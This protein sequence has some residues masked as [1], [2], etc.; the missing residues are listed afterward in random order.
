MAEF[1]Q[2]TTEVPSARTGAPMVEQ[3]AAH[4]TR[5]PM[6]RHITAAVAAVGSIALCATMA[7]AGGSTAYADTY[8]STQAAVAATVTSGTIPAGQL[9]VVNF[10]PTWGD[11]QAN[12][13]SMLKYIADA[14]ANGV[15]MIVFPEMAL[16]GYVSSNDPDSAAYR[17]AVSQA[18][19]TESPITR[20]IAQAAAAN[21]M[22][23]IYGTSEKIPGDTSHAYN[24]AFAI[25]PKGHT[26]RSHRSKATGPHRAVRQS[27]CR[28][29]GA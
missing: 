14:H 15:K 9:A 23:V 22:W 10:H 11:K 28:P 20:E 6:K 25:S 5:F 12:K 19:T 18:E 8:S 24:S 7:F 17:M 27:F 3:A 13:A 26:R 2:S 1:K 4:T 29:N 16:T 21:G